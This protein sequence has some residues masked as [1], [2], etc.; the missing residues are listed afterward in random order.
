MSKTKRILSVALT[1]FLVTVLLIPT[2][3]VQ[4]ASATITVSGTPWGVSTC[5]IGAT[6]GNVRFNV[7]DLQDAGL[8]TYRIYGGMSRWERQDD[9]G[10]YGSPSIDAIKANPNLVNW[11]WWDNIMTTPNGSDYHWS[12]EPGI[13]WQGNART[14]FQY[15]RYHIRPADLGNVDNNINRALGRTNLTRRTRRRLERVVGM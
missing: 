1:M 4:A 5:Y 14:I 11:T 9:D 2:T 7:A 15:R 12:G 6:E 8:N 13:T 10:V 3:I